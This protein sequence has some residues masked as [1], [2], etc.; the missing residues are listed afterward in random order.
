MSKVITRYGMPTEKVSPGAQRRHSS[1]PLHSSALV[2]MLALLVALPGVASETP[3]KMLKMTMQLVDTKSSARVALSRPQTFYRAGTE[4]LRVEE[5]LDEAH[6][7][8]QLVIHNKNDL[9]GI[10][11]ERKEGQHFVG[12]SNKTVHVS[13]PIM[14]VRKDDWL[15]G[16]EFGNELSFVKAN[17][18]KRTTDKDTTIYTVDKNS[19]Q[20]ILAVNTASEKPLWISLERGKAKYKF[21]YLT[22][23]SIDFDPSKF[24]PSPEIKIVE[25]KVKSI[26]AKPPQQKGTDTS[27]ETKGNSAPSPSET[28]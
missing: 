15:N 14:V 26:A 12:Q 27:K 25:A 6:H 16:L 21:E 28:H 24:K 4:Y 3:D 20:I 19:D 23:E 7:M 17:G 13:L 5:S 8:H 2:S 18:A 9:W 1:L 11:L 22:Y 10:E